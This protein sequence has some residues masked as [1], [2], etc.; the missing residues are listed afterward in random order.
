MRAYFAYGGGK[1]SELG[2]LDPAKLDELLGRAELSLAE[3][4][5]ESQF[6]LGVCR[7]DSDFAQ[8][9]PVGKGEYLLWSDRIV[10]K[11]GLLGLFTP[12]KPICPV[13][14]GRGAALEALHM[15]TASSREEFEARYG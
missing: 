9:T 13:L 14:K 4:D 5:V 8:V 15:Y 2:P 3:P 7:S 10:K 6:G 1:I 11:G 12:A